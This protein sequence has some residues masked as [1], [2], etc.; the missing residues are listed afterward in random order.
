MCGGGGCKT[1][2][3]GVAG[4]WW[5]WWERVRCCGAVLEGGGKAG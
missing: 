2:E 3:L 1:D 4:G 5:W